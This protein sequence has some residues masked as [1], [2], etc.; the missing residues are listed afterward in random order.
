VTAARP[1][2]N[3]WLANNALTIILAII[4]VQNVWN[5]FNNETS[6]QLATLTERLAGIE[7]NLLE[8]SARRDAQ[9][10]GVSDRLL[11][12]ERRR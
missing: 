9:I 12:L 11:V 2:Q 8:A 4:A 7:R 5:S 1:T 3:S 6:R 10:N